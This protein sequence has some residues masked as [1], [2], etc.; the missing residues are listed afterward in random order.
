M[1]APSRPPPA[2]S[3]V[4]S[5][6]TSPPT[7]SVA[8]SR[9]VSGC[10]FPG[11]RLGAREPPP[12]PRRLRVTALRAAAKVKGL[13]RVAALLVQ[14]LT[15]S[16]EPTSSGAELASALADESLALSLKQTP[17]GTQG[18]LCKAYVAGVARVLAA[19]PVRA[20]SEEPDEADRTEL[21]DALTRAWHA[22]VLA[23]ERV[24][25]KTAAKDLAAAAERL[26]ARCLATSTPSRE[27]DETN[28]A[29]ILGDED[30]LS[31]QLDDDV[32]TSVMER[33]EALADGVDVPFCGPKAK[34]AKRR[35]RPR[36]H[37]RVEIESEQNGRR[38]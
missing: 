12:T 28:D 21:N 37:A 11:A 24:K 2:S 13:S 34:A 36:C 14:L 9:A 5:A 17:T 19:V 20:A 26:R 18:T 4:S 33:A 31:T 8:P 16:E 6:V 1:R 15:A 29:E 38:E 3:R 30:D 32:R 25:E 10:L 22:A 35:R 7:L 27:E 23:A